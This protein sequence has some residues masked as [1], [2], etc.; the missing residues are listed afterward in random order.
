MSGMLTY[1]GVTAV[2]RDLWVA[3]LRSASGDQWAEVPDES[4]A[5]GHLPS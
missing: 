2:C 5:H 1:M 4:G 3:D